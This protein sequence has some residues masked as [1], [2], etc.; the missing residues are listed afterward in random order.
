MDIDKLLIVDVRSIPTGL[1]PDVWL[2]LIENQ[3]VV[4]WDST[5][6]EGLHPNE[7]QAKKDGPWRIVNIRT[8]SEDER[9]ELFKSLNIEL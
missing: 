8:L 2:N 7:P 6:V 9:D 1:D 4:L 3:N 5:P